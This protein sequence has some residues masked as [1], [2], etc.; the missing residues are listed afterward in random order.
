MTGYYGF[1]LKVHL[2]YKREPEMSGNNSVPTL[3]DD[4][5]EFV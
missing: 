1:S 3:N 2:K 4:T 5:N